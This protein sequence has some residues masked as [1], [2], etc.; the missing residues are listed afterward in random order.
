MRP[1]LRKHASKM[2]AVH[3]VL[4]HQ[5]EHGFATRLLQ[6]GPVL[7]VNG[8]AGAARSIGFCNNGRCL[9][10]H[11]SNMLAVHLERVGRRGL[12]NV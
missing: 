6:H 4:R 11:A 1:R 3:V 5:M 12:I 7:A 2:L 8:A 10:Q 9:G